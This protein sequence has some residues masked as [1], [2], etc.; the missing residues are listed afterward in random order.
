MGVGLL[1]RAV[2]PEVVEESWAVALT[3]PNKIHDKW[4]CGPAVFS[5]GCEM[6]VVA[7]FSVLTNREALN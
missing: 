6:P 3:F 7:D 5:Q 4:K 2:Y 1:M